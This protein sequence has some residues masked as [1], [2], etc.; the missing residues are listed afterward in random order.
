MVSRQRW[1]LSHPFALRQNSSQHFAFDGAPQ[2]LNATHPSKTTQ[3]LKLYPNPS[4][5]YKH[6]LTH[7]NT[8]THLGHKFME[9]SLWCRLQQLRICATIPC[10][11]TSSSSPPMERVS[12]FLLTRYVYFRI[13]PSHPPHQAIPKPNI[14][15][16]LL[17][18]DVQ[19]SRIYTKRAKAMRHKNSFRLQRFET[20]ASLL[21]LGTDSPA[22]PQSSPVRHPRC[23]I[24]LT[25]T[26]SVVSPAIYSRIY[27]P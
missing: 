13:R 16:L 9:S 14:H 1:M 18:H 20:N 26:H 6:I 19:F 3:I 8:H 15:T 27:L 17:L 24:I 11:D 10:D 2:T 23:H 22:P 7:T 5:R 21:P 12:I 25:H 4:R